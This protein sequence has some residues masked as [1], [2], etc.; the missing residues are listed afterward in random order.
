MWDP[1]QYLKFSEERARPFFDLLSQVKRERVRHAVDLGCGPGELTHVLAERRNWP[2]ANF[3]GVDNSP[4]M[5]EKARLLTIVGRLTFELGDIATWKSD[6]PLDLIV[7]NAA[8]HWVPDHARLLP[9]LAE[10]LAP[11]GTIAVQMPSR[12][13]TPAQKAI[14]ETVRQPRWAAL[15]GLG[16][17][18]DCVMPIA[19]YVERLHDLAFEVNAWETIYIHVLSGADPVLEWL[20]GTA[21]RPLLNRLDAEAK[22]RFLAELAGRLRAAYPASGAYTLFPFPRIFFVATKK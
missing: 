7:S 14:D 17:Q 19:W 12:F 3:I 8:L 4:E 15:K 5:L 10:M 22:D 6:V 21:L 20:K 13:Q 9:A 16:L 1:Q 18:P 2:A 11:G